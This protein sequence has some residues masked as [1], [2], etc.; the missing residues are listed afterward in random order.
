MMICLLFVMVALVFR[1]VTLPGAGAGLEF[2]LIPDFE[3]MFGGGIGHFGE[4]V[5][6]A[7]GQAF[8]TLSLGIGAMEVFGSLHWQRSRAH[9]RSAAH[10]RSRYVRGDRGGP[11]HLSCVLRVR[12]CS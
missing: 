10:L 9:G 4:V 11:H 1:S 8:F 6:A 5:Y 3:K 12:C 2:Y 7:M